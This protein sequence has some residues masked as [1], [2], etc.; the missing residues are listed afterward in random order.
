MIQ[1]LGSLMTWVISLEHL[2]LFLFLV[3]LVSILVSEKTPESMM[4]WIF[5]ITVFPFGGIVL[6]LLFGVNWR[7][8]RVISSQDAV[9]DKRKARNFL[10]YDTAQAFHSEKLKIGNPGKIRNRKQGKKNI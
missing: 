4:A 6:Y 2:H 7:K 8:R 9:K 1:S 10:E 3:F 5:T